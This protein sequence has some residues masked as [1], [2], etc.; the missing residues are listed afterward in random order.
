MNA[1]VQSMLEGVHKRDRAIHRSIALNAIHY[2]LGC[3]VAANRV[4]FVVNNDEVFI[5]YFGVTLAASGTGKDRSDSI[6]KS[7]LSDVA[8]AYMYALEK[9][10]SA[11]NSKLGP[12][13]KPVAMPPF[14]FERATPEGFL[15]SRVDIQA[16]GF[17]I[18]NLKIPELQDALSSKDSMDFISDVVKTWETGETGAKTNRASPIPATKDQPTNILI[19]GSPV[20]IEEK[21]KKGADLRDRMTSGLARRSFVAYPSIHETNEL[22]KQSLE[23]IT[24]PE[25]ISDIQR[26]VNSKVLDAMTN[27]I[28]VITID[29]DANQKYL[30][31]DRRCKMESIGERNEA[32]TA[33]L[34]SRAWK[35]IRLAALYA[36]ING[37]ESIKLHDVMDAIEFTDECGLQATELLRTKSPQELLL[38]YLELHGPVRREEIMRVVLGHN[39]IKDF[40]DTLSL[41]EELADERSMV[42][43]ITK[44]KIPLYSIKKLE[45][46]DLDAVTISIGTSMGDGWR[47]ITGKFSALGDVLASNIF[48]S[49]GTFKD[50]KR[51]NENYEQKQD[52]MIF[53]ID[54]GM[55]LE[56]AKAF[57]S[58][59]KCIIATT[60][61]HMKEKHPGKMDVCDRFRIVLVPDSK[62]ELDPDT[63]SQFMLNAMDM[64]GIPADRKAIDPA[65]FFFG[66]E[67]AEVWYSPGGRRFP[68]KAALPTTTVSETVHKRLEKYDSVDGIERYFIASTDTGERNNK[69]YRY[70]CVLKDEGYD[71]AEIEEK[72]ISL[73]QKIADPLPE[74]EV[75][76]TIIRSISK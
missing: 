12:T 24:P 61:S 48:Y 58:D 52:L 54:E 66:Y 51:N 41:A 27:G 1:I 38:D 64:M 40:Q 25:D 15:Q 63:Y 71:L 30:E 65:R 36:F 16:V 23:T 69:L 68:V 60:K 67:D 74:R 37:Q 10:Y 19:Y 29:D 20:G 4:K 8:D 22:M 70:A 45:G 55:T 76:Q 39:R 62:I 56:T 13:D 14:E 9:N 28:R 44:D 11:F 73:N 42:I 46:I 18:T 59:F 33:E 26:E 43:E 2:N 7:M 5:N 34:R 6:V 49:A 17:G 53:D 72:V 31:Y 21:N 50:G 75:R 47:S 3:L 57:F 35:M 32:I